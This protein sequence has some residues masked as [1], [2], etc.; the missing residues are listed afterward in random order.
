ML[1]RA[2]AKDCCSGCSPKLKQCCTSPLE[3]LGISSNACSCMVLPKFCAPLMSPKFGAEYAF[4]PLETAIW[5]MLAIS[6][7]GL[8]IPF[9]QLCITTKELLFTDLINCFF[10]LSLVI[11]FSYHKY[12]TVYNGETYADAAFLRNAFLI[13][14]ACYILYVLIFAIWIFASKK[15]IVNLCIRTYGSDISDELMH[16]CKTT[17]MYKLAVVTLM[18]TVFIYLPWK[19]WCLITMNKNCY[20]LRDGKDAALLVPDPYMSG[21]EWNEYFFIYEWNEHFS[22]WASQGILIIY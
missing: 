6:T 9:Y 12:Q 20:E 19:I 7:L 21:N 2:K 4:L 14:M 8:G 18:Y 11:L 5:A 15:R 17:N 10:P 22:K 3:F 13:Q 16:E 1:P